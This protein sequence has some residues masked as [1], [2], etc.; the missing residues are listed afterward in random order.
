MK[1]LKQLIEG[2]IGIPLSLLLQDREVVPL[3]GTEDKSYM[4]GSEIAKKEGAYLAQGEIDSFI[5]D[6]PKGYFLLAH[7]GHGICSHALYYQRADEWSRLFFRLPFA[8]AF[9]DHREASRLIREFLLAFLDFEGKIK[10]KVVSIVFVE[11]M[12]EGMYQIE[13]KKGDLIELRESLL[14]N[15]N[16]KERFSIL[17]E[18]NK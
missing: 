13:S 11:S 15:P 3:Y 9:E 4:F 18:E 6:C 2:E 1:A 10:D 7:W 12:W 17:F 8:N 14:K 16:F 5:R